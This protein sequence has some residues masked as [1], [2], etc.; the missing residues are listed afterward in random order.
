MPHREVLETLLSVITPDNSTK[1]VNAANPMEILFPE[2]GMN[3]CEIV[4][5]VN[6]DDFSSSKIAHAIEDCDVH[7]VNMNLTSVRTAE[8]DLVVALRTTGS[9]PTAVARS[10]ERY[11]FRV[12]TYAGQHDDNLDY[13]SRRR[14]AELLHIL[15]L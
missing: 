5:A 9:N 7:L 10:L 11:G 4:I 3:Y 15:E 6:P 13:E 1:T 12:I 8:S 14:A 2:G